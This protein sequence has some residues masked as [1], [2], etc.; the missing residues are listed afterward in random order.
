MA[1]GC[2]RGGKE[3]K[4]LFDVDHKGGGGHDEEMHVCSHGGGGGGGHVGE[5]L[6]LT[7]EDGLVKAWPFRLHDFFG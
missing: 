1:A 5:L 3:T 7:R 2:G 6:V 4:V